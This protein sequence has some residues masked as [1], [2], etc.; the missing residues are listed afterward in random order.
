MAE[1]QIRRGNENNTNI[2]SFL[3]LNENICCDPSSE[4]SQRDGF[5]DG[6]QCKFYGKLSLFPLLIW[7]TAMVTVSS[8]C[9][10]L[11]NTLKPVQC[12]GIKLYLQM[13]SLNK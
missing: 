1:L 7:S 9:S 13:Y 3:F 6:S 8:Q 2:F 4:L 12:K 11:V 10:S 5:N